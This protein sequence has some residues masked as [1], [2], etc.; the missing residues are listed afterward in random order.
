MMQLHENILYFWIEYI[1]FL[2]YYFL[3]I[4]SNP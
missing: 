3:S 1:S 4:F 2:F